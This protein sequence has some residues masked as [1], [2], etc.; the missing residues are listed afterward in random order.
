MCPHKPSK[1]VKTV[2]PA[3]SDVKKEVD[4]LDT[5]KIMPKRIRGGGSDRASPA[6]IS[7]KPLKQARKPVRKLVFP[8]NGI[9]EEESGEG[10]SSI[11][12]VVEEKYVE[13]TK[14]VLDLSKDLEQSNFG[15]AIEI[16][17]THMEIKIEQRASVAARPEAGTSASGFLAQFSSLEPINLDS[18]EHTPSPIDD[19]PLSSIYT[20]L[21][22]SK[23]PSPTPAPQPKPVDV[24]ETNKWFK[25]PYVEP[26]QTLLLD[27]QFE[28]STEIPQEYLDEQAR[29]DELDSK[30]VKLDYEIH[31]LEN[32]HKRRV[33]L[34]AAL[35][36]A[37][38][39]TSTSTTNPPEPKQSSPSTIKIL[40]EHLNGEL[41]STQF[42]PT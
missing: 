21:Q 41:P 42:E 9:V 26:L 16:L 23:T 32:A 5:L 3:A 38:L 27:E 28:G 35:A 40:S 39:S 15:K 12:Q 33:A 18:S 34:D 25:V 1:K 20:K 2:K 10:G 14:Q 31:Y 7:K 37:A 6:Q 30:R 19:Q 4:E 22:K 29:L 11:A 24:P 36:V 8:P 13:A 17:K